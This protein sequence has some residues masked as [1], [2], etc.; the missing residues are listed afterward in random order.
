MVADQG[1]EVKWL[2]VNRNFGT[3]GIAFAA[4]RPSQGG[5]R[6]LYNL[7]GKLYGLGNCMKCS[8]AVFAESLPKDVLNIR[9]GVSPA[10]QS[11][12]MARDFRNR[13]GEGSWAECGWFA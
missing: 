13:V 7:S 4:L 5:S 11:R 9:D 1:R 6:N 3:G 10:V 8:I 2:W 12:L